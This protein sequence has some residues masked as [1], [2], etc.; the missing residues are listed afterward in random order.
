MKYVA[1]L[2]Y[3]KQVQKLGLGHLGN[4]TE[5]QSVQADVG[6]DTDFVSQSSSVE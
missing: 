3:L 1:V 2:S 6:S 5:L 4:G